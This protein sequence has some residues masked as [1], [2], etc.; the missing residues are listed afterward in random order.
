MQRFGMKRIRTAPARP[1]APKDGEDSFGQ[2]CVHLRE[3]LHATQAQL[4]EWFA[5]SGKTFARWEDGVA[6][7]TQLL[8]QRTRI[9]HD[10]IGCVAHPDDR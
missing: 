5:V 8:G 9:G 10:R 1:R 2:V 6:F 3:S 4:G 7:P